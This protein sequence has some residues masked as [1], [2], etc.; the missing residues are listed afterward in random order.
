MARFGGGFC[1]FWAKRRLFRC[2][3]DSRTR[4]VGALPRTGS[5]NPPIQDQSTPMASERT[6]SHIEDPADALPRTDVDLESELESLREFISKGPQFLNHRLFVEV[7]EIEGRFE[8]VIALL[9]KEVRRA[10]R[11]CRDEQRI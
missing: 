8:H 2:R 7:E 9:P 5:S 3:P 4:D 6:A 1:P 11:I 10:R